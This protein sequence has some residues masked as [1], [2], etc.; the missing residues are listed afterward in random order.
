MLPTIADKKSS[1]SAFFL[2]RTSKRMKQFFQERLTAA[3]SDI[4]IDQWVILQE[5]Q[6][7][8]GQ[9]Q[10]DIARATYKDAATLTRII[11]LLCKKEL[12][13]RVADDTDRRRFNVFLTQDGHTKI[14][15]VLPIIQE[16]RSRAWAG[17]SDEA[18]DHLVKTLNHIYDNL[19]A[20][21]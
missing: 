18:V 8:D 4:T 9:S 14:A 10:M 21:S 19:T 12:T 6:R 13:K 3:Q 17:L 11:D 1:V 5:L 15:D 16:C 2:E 20:P 7:Q